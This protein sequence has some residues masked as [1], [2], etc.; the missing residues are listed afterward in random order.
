MLKKLAIASMTT[1]LAISI[2]GCADMRGRDVGVVSG[3]ALGGV[4]GNVLTGGT[5]VGTAVGAVGGGVAGYHIGK[6]Q[7]KRR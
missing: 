2:T 6:S 4:A 5:P 7:E 1:L 3:A